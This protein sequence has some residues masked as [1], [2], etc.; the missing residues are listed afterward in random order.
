MDGKIMIMDRQIHEP[1][2]PKWC[3]SDKGSW[4]IL[5]C[6]QKSETSI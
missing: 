6:N 5:N 4:K 2:K 3:V 1:G